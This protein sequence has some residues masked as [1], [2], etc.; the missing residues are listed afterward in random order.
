MNATLRAALAVALGL[1]LALPAAASDITVSARGK[2]QQALQQGNVTGPKA[3]YEE[4]LRHR[5]AKFAH[6]S[7]PFGLA[8]D[9]KGNLYVA[10]DTGN[11]ISI[12]NSQLKVL[13]TTITQGVSTPDAVAVDTNNNIYVG[14]YGAR[15]VTKYNSLYTLVGTITANA[16][17][18]YSIA[19]DAL[20]D[21]YIVTDYGLSL[22]DPYGDGLYSNVFSGSLFSVAVGE[23]YVYAFYANAAAFG[24]GSVALR[25][26]T[27]QEDVGPTSAAAIGS[28]CSSTISAC[29]W[30]D[31]LNLS[32]TYGT[33][34]GQSFS[35]GLPYEPAGVAVD[36]G[37][38]RLFVADPTNNAIHLYNATTLT[39]EKTIT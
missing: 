9:G 8:L 5:R 29:W 35:V 17:P 28:A 20:Q 15:D 32:L 18:A 6:F 10:N 7:L 24:N 25:Y 31:A 16:S 33:L 19:V 22:D 12:V 2:V 30:D 11:Y 14:N 23:P 26:G 37:R 1:P 39:L 27:L 4:I 38:N 13:P 21:I 34:P 3:V 36:I